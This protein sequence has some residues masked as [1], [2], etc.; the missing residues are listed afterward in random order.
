MV[1]FN[2]I[3]GNADAHRKNFSLFEQAEGLRLSPAYD[4]VNTLVYPDYQRQAALEIGGAKREFEALDR[5]LI[6]R[7]GTDNGLPLGAVRGR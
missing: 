5:S 3:I 7:L 1:V 6:E 2:L 4:L